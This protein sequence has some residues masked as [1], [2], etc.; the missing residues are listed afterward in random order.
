MT[1]DVVHLASKSFDFR[2]LALLQ[3]HERKTAEMTTTFGFSLVPAAKGLHR[4]GFLRT[5]AVV[6]PICG[7]H[8]PMLAV[9]FSFSTDVGC[10]KDRALLYEGNSNGPS[11]TKK[12]LCTQ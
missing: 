1:S 8:Q 10:Q 7:L 9:H 3:E 11:G 4:H 6:H 5:F 12:D 2:R